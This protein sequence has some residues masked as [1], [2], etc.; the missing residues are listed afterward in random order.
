MMKDTEQYPEMV[1]DILCSKLEVRPGELGQTNN[2]ANTQTDTS[3][4]IISLLRFPVDSQIVHC[5]P[6][7]VM[8]LYTLKISAYTYIQREQLSM[9][10]GIF[11][12]FPDCGF[13]D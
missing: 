10:L 9:Q 3:K 7:N 8:Y 5:L 13:P 6:R 12:G 11:T 2:K 1:M 4:C